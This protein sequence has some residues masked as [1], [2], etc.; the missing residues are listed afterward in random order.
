VIISLPNIGHGDVRLSLL[1]G[2]FKYADKGLLDATHL[3]FYNRE[4]VLE[5]VEPAG[6][7]VA[8]LFTIDVPLGATERGPATDVPD[9]AVEFVLS[10]PDSA[11]YQ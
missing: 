8:D 10:D 5:L 9:E 3:H 2:R 6:L 1:S 4:S 7:E 11:V